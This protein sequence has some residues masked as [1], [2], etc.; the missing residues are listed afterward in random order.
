MGR[1]RGGWTTKI[2]LVAADAR[3]AITFALSPGQAH[4]APEVR[5][6]LQ[7][8]GRML[9][10]GVLCAERLSAITWISRPLG[11][12]TT[13]SVRNAT[14][15]A[16]VCRCAVLPNTSPVFVLNAAYRDNVP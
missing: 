6:L 11:W 2:H 8:V 10:R 9:T 15:S 7:R 14:N 3:T 5:K 1:S 12:L 16:E 13:R 4:D